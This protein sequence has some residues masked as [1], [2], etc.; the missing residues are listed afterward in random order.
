M[1]K[2]YAQVSTFAFEGVRVFCRV[3][4]TDSYGSL[5][6]EIEEPVDGKL[7]CLLTKIPRDDDVRQG[8][9]VESSGF[10]SKEDGVPLGAGLIP[11]KQ[12]VGVI[13]EVRKNEKFQEAVVELNADYRS[14]KYVTILK[15]NSL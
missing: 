12:P 2:T 10:G 13:L 1:H 9:K 11:E 3:R 5:S 6:G 8:M 14:F 15:K 7:R 4:G